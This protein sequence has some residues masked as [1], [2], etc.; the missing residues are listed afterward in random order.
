MADALIR[1]R[2]I[3]SITTSRTRLT[4]YILWY[5]PR[6]AHYECVKS[7]L[8]MDS[9]DSRFEVYSFDDDGLLRYQNKIY[10]LD[11]EGL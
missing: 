6:D 5:L 7:V 4:K 9:L 3:T 11:S 10:V 8:D 1:R 2:H